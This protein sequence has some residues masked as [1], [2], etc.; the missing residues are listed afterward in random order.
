MTGL[1][2]RSALVS[3]AGNGIGRGIAMALAAEGAHVYLAERDA[4]AVAA[5]EAA[6]RAAGG[7]AT[8][9]VAD[10]TRTQ[11]IEAGLRVI[12]AAHG[13]LDILVNNAGINVRSDF[14]HLSEADWV[15]VRDV[16]LDGVVRL[17]RNGFE[18]L[19]RSGNA[20][21]INIA[22]ILGDH[23]VRQLVAYSATKGAV[24]AF[25]KGLAVEWATFGIR[26]NAVCPGFVE[27]GMTARALRMPAFAKALLDK[28]PMRRF[29][30]PEEIAAAVVFLASDKA[31][32]VTGATLAVDGGMTAHL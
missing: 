16:N 3:G 14:R 6:I 2:G 22:S 10:V 15:T 23:G 29:G 17:A 21:V 4:E 11:D 30:T 5:V 31:S 28:T 8:A 18:L 25:T 19:R 1:D 24:I 32:Y 9:I 26:V 13:K 27:T 12:E 7:Q 20:S